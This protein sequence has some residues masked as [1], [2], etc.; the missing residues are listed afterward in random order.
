MAGVRDCLSVRTGANRLPSA[1]RS[2]TL[3][4]RKSPGSTSVSS[5]SQSSG[6]DTG[7]PGSGRSE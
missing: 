6:V 1:N 5:S 2:Q 7:A 4:I 3:S